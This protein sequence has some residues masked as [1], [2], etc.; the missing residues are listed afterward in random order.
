MAET[1]EG[2]P[3]GLHWRSGQRQGLLFKQWGQQAD[4][5]NVG[6]GERENWREEILVFSHSRE[7]LKAPGLNSL[8]LLPPHISLASSRILYLVPLLLKTSPCPTCI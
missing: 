7:E 3:A 2:G 6:V 1:L 4:N 5:V 8:T